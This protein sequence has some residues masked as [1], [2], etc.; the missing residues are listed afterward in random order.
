MSL[1]RFI[2]SILAVVADKSDQACF[3]TCGEGHVLCTCQHVGLLNGI[4]DNSRSIVGHLAAIRSVSLVAVVLGRVVGCGDHDACVAFIES[5]SKAESRN[6][7]QLVI[8]TD[9]DPVSCENARCV[10]GEVPSFKTAVVADRNCLCSALCLYPV[11]NT[12]RC[13]ANDPDVHTVG[14]RTESTAKTC[15]TELKSNRK[16]ILYR[17][18]VAFDVAQFFSEVVINK[19]GFEPTFVIILIHM[20]NPP[21]H[22]FISYNNLIGKVVGLQ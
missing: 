6:R 13:L 4:I 10:S 21:F 15:G 12:L 5:G 22:D 17:I 9:I 7:H 19:I 11:R 14:A 1:D 16:A 18:V 20:K 3:H 8:Y 2:E